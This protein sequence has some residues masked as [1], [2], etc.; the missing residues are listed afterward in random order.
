LNA[1]SS[2]TSLQSMY[3][4]EFS[5]NFPKQ[6]FDMFLNRFLRKVDV[7]AALFDVQ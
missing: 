7:L 4:L 2:R 1:V 6:L 5:M 3:D